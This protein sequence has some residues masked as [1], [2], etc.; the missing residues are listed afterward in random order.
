MAPP[1]AAAFSPLPHPQQRGAGV[2]RPVEPLALFHI[3][4]AL[5]F[6]F[7]LTFGS[8]VLVSRA[9]AEA[10]ST[11]PAASSPRPPAPRRSRSSPSAPEPEAATAAQRRPGHLRRPPSRVDPALR[12]AF[13]SDAPPL[14]ADDSA[15]N[16][17]GSD[18]RRG[19]RFPRRRSTTFPTASPRGSS[20]IRGPGAPAAT[21]AA[22]WARTARSSSPPTSPSTAAATGIRPCTAPDGKIIRAACPICSTSS[23]MVARP[24]RRR[25]AGEPLDICR[26]TKS[27]RSSRR[28]SCSPGTG[29][30]S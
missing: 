9:A 13:T 7:V 8:V 20:R 22:A 12:L 4:V 10:I 27:S 19:R 28:L 17:R 1:S 15:S 11:I 23:A 16:L 21:A 25:A 24:D 30:S 26:A 6:L 5:H 2:H 14:R 18:H 3:S 29:I